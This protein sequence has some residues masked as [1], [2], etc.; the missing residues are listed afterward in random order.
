MTMNLVFDSVAPPHG[1]QGCARLAAP[2][3]VIAR[4]MRHV[5]PHVD[6]AHRPR[7]AGMARSRV[8]DLLFALATAV[9]LIAVLLPLAD[10]TRRPD[11]ADRLVRL[12][13][14]LGQ[15]AS[16]SSLLPQGQPPEAAAAVR[17]S[18]ASHEVARGA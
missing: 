11:G 1:A 4:A 12:N 3:S 16:A 10:A 15:A 17:S 8:D 6:E 5:E 2:R 13:D 7:A 14:H 18:S 9:L